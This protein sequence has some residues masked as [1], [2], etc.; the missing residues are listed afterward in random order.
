MR[1]QKY[2]I[3]FLLAFHIQIF[4]SECEDEFT[5]IL[6]QL[7]TAEDQIVDLHS[8]AEIQITNIRTQ[9]NTQVTEIQNQVDEWRNE[10]K[11][12]KE[13]QAVKLRSLFI[14]NIDILD[15]RQRS[16]INNVLKLHNIHSIG[17]LI[18]QTRKDLLQLYGLGKIAV[19]LIE[20]ELEKKGLSLGMEI[21]VWPLNLEQAAVLEISHLN[22]STR[23]HQ[24]FERE[25]IYYLGDLIQY[26]SS[27]L[28]RF[29][30]FGR[31]S[32]N[33]VV[34]Y[35]KYLGDRLSI[36]LSLGIHIQNWQELR[37]QQSTSP[38]E[39]DSDE[40]VL[41]VSDQ[42]EQELDSNELKPSVPEQIEPPHRIETLDHRPPV[43][44]IRKDLI[45]TQQTF[46][47]LQEN[48]ISNLR[49]LVEL[50]E[51]EFL[52]LPGAEQV[53]GNEIKKKLAEIGLY[54]G[55]T[56]WTTLSHRHL[57]EINL[58]GEFVK[59]QTIM[60]R[61]EKPSE[62]QPKLKE[63]KDKKSLHSL[64]DLRLD[65]LDLSVRARNAFKEMDFKYVG[66][67]ISYS[68]AD[69]LSLGIGETSLNQFTEKLTGLGL[70][71]EMDIEDW[72]PP[73][74]TIRETIMNEEQDLDEEGPAQT[75]E[76]ESSVDQTT[77]LEMVKPE[78]DTTTGIELWTNEA[79]RIESRRALIQKN[80]SV[81][82]TPEFVRWVDKKGNLSKN[83]TD[84]IK[85]IVKRFQY[86]G[87]DSLG[88]TGVHWEPLRSY[89]GLYQRKININS[90]GAVIIYF[91]IKDNKLYLLLGERF[92]KGR[93]ARRQNI[94]KAGKLMY[95]YVP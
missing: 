38:S 67:V 15:F 1:L 40:P 37:P 53:H 41:P 42:V 3:Y 50:T 91:T 29:A 70:Y 78:S 88:Q 7:K 12:L 75:S 45:F 2:F 79:S 69:L 22:F 21:G 6:G 90:Q 63:I 43:N 60:P 17:D 13:K 39:Q 59:P 85:L 92:G 25:N 4:A 16:F 10:L 81:Y 35:L 95:D 11:E 57:S 31:S 33:E 77:E 55:I 48:S 30:N 18:I 68:S 58:H 47:V 36:N 5:R 62:E 64:F 94:N 52:D 82:Y 51:E 73:M 93:N 71:L 24:I 54:F 80:Q 44:I 83:I 65:G 14:Q 19:D 86:E 9:T 32:L 20:T 61:E 26:E 27:A 74:Y 84:K 89:A 76:E 8:Q 28:L 46:D 87:I 34:G 66:D 49:I 23:V 56:D 72:S